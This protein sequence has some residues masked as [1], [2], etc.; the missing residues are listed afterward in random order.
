[1]VR[2]PLERLRRLAEIGGEHVDRVAG[3]PLRK[4]DC[5]VDA[6]IEADQDA[7]RLIAYILDRVA[8]ALR[9]VAD[10]T[11]LELLGAEAAVRAEQRDADIACDDIL[12]F[13]GVRVPM[14][15]AQPAGVEIED[16]TGDGLRN[17][18]AAGIHAPLATTGEGRM[19]RLSQEA[20]FVRLR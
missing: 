15:R 16:D 2:K 11:L 19:R 7:R 17:R 6:G 12:P 14:Q 4:V 13:I 3:D 20:I 9:D 1:P 8:V 5:L 18:E 10:V